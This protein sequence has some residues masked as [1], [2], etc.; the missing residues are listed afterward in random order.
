M[1]W[2]VP[3]LDEMRNTAKKTS[4]NAQHAIQSAPG[5]QL[6]H[7]LPTA[8]KS[9]PKGNPFQSLGTSFSCRLASGCASCRPPA[10]REVPD[11]QKRAK[12]IEHHTGTCQT[13]NKTHPPS[14]CLRASRGTTE[15]P[16]SSKNIMK[17]SNHSSV[18]LCGSS[19][20]PLTARNIPD[21]SFL[22]A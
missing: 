7:T 4:Q 18:F 9:I 3:N 12:I 1:D 16:A 17:T 8:F 2:S 22:I 5:K 10:A 15:H 14:S 21:N 6:K 19:G 13:H 20:L 11:P